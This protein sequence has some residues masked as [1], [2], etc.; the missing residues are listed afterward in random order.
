MAFNVGD[1]DW[2]NSGRLTV[3]SAESP[4]LMPRP[5]FT[6]RTLLRLMLVV[7]VPLWAIPRLSIQPLLAALALA[8]SAVAVAAFARSNASDDR[9][10]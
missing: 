9:A 3:L 2:A 10:R 8:W 7:V 5:Q 6:I 1:G 4:V